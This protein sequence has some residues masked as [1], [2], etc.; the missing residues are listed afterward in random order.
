MLVNNLKPVPVGDLSPATGNLAYGLKITFR[1]FGQINPIKF[2]C[3]T[4]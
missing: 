1:N 4:S 2:G 3:T